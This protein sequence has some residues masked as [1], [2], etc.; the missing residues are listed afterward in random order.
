MLLQIT[1]ILALGLGDA[2]VSDARC[3]LF[4][5]DYE[6]GVYRWATVGDSSVVANVIEDAGRK[7]CVCAVC[8]CGC[9]T[10]AT[11]GGC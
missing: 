8:S 11:A 10:V 6:S 1:G 9:G 7:L 2:A 5:A 4:L 3:G